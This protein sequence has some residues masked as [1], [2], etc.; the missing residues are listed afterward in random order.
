MLRLTQKEA[1]KLAK[2]VDTAE[3]LMSGNDLINVCDFMRW[4]T[5][6]RPDSE[7]KAAIAELLI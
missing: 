5:S 6:D 3:R 7:K 4:L 1:N 2:F